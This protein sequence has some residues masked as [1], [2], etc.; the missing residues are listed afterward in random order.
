MGFFKELGNLTKSLSGNLDARVDQGLWFLKN[1]QVDN[2]MNCFSSASLKGHPNATRLWGELLIDYGVGHI[3]T[4]GGLMKL[5]RAITIGS[6]FA[7]GSYSLYKNKSQVMALFALNDE[8]LD[9]T[10]SAVMS[11]PYKQIDELDKRML[12]KIIFEIRQER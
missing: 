11:Q 1:D 6:T 5:K 3:D 7:E 4:L 2:A 9:D 10:R 8:V 12:D